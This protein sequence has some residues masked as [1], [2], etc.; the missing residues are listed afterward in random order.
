M[1]YDEILIYIPQYTNKKETLKANKL[2]AYLME[3]PLRGDGVGPA[4]GD[5]A[6]GVDRAVVGGHVARRLLRGGRRAGHPQDER[7]QPLVPAEGLP[8]QLGPRHG[9]VHRQVQLALH[10]SLRQNREITVKIRYCDNQ[11]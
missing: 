10:R 5:L 7:V 4:S 3:D 6:H 8:R 1:I 11:I 2:S 9:A